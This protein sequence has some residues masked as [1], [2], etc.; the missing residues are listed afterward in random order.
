M[1]QIHPTAQVSQEY[2]LRIW[3]VLDNLEQ[4]GFRRWHTHVNLAG[5]AARSRLTKLFRPCCYVLYYINTKFIDPKD[6]TSIAT[7]MTSYYIE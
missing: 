5:P 4:I 3:K 6:I 2:M 1:F 7:A